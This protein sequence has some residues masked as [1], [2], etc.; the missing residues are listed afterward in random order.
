[1][2]LKSSISRT[3]FCPL[4]GLLVGSLV[5]ILAPQAHA[6]SNS[7]FEVGAD[8]NYVRSNAPPGGCTC[9]SL[10]GGDASVAYHFDSA[11]AAVAEISSVHASN[12]SGSGAD[13][14]LTSYLFG[15][16]YY[17]HNHTKF[18]P[19]GQ[20][21]LGGAHAGTSLAGVSSDANAF[22]AKIGGGVD[23]ALTHRFSLRPFEANYYLTHFANG[24]NDHQNNLQLGAGLVFHF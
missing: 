6:Q 11:F 23:Y 3:S 16:R 24:T 13:L 19:F 7:K 22:A 1:M 9:F 15:P 12:I 20:V 2:N 4:L 8:Y 17:W 5:F 14:T 10:N 21:L 18:T